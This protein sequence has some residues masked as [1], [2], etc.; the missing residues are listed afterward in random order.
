MTVPRYNLLFM[1]YFRRRAYR[2]SFS[3]KLSAYRK[4]VLRNSRSCSLQSEFHTSPNSI[5]RAEARDRSGGLARVPSGTIHQSRVCP[6]PCPATGR[7]VS[8]RLT[9]STIHQARV[10]PGPCPANSIRR[11]DH[12]D[13][14]SGPNGL[15]SPPAFRNEL[16]PG[17]ARYA[18]RIIATS[19]AGPMVLFH[20][21][22]SGTN[23]QRRLAAG[24]KEVLRFRPLSS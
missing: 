6:G 15:I 9:A 14:S 7:A 18:E 4:R 11:A 5:R 16:A 13:Q 1:E 23:C 3:P 17:P 19:R 12:S 2:V 24:L 22:P 20:H 10:C 21:R 8:A